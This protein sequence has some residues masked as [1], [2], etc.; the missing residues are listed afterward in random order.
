VH[1]QKKSVKGQ[2]GQNKGKQAENKGE[3][4]KGG[5]GK[6]CGYAA[7]GLK[8]HT[9]DECHKLKA[10]L[11]KHRH[12][13]QKDSKPFTSTIIGKSMTFSESTSRKSSDFEYESCWLW[14]WSLEMVQRCGRNT[15][16]QGESRRG[17]E[18]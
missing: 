18:R 16:E 17:E 12:L 4:D 13:K 5:N 14:V 8:G 1:I 10:V 15:Y 9:K 6:Q 7:C 11:N 3:K 2:K